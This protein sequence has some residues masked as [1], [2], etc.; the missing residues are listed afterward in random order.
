[1]HI[2]YKILPFLQDGKFHSGAILA[3]SLEISRSNIW[4]GIQFLRGLGLPI[5]AV[6]GRG[7]R[8]HVPTEL[9]DK[10]CIMKM[11][12]P[13]VLAYLY[14][15]DLFHVVTSTNDY[16]MQR[17]AD[18][19]SGTVCLAEAQTQ[20]KGRQ[21]KKWISP[22]GANIYLSLYHCFPKKLLDLSGLSLVVALAILEMLQGVGPLPLAL[23]IKWPND[24]WFE[25]KKLAGIL[26]E[27]LPRQDTTDIVIGIGLNVRLPFTHQEG[28]DLQ[29]IFPCVPSR[30]Q[31]LANLLNTLVPHLILFQ[32]EGFSAFQ[33]A[34]TE[35]DLLRNKKVQLK[36]KQN[37]QVGWAEGVNERG[38]LC[39]RIDGVLKAI[40]YGEISVRQK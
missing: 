37:T 31:L 29:S 22:Y 23:G 24:V 38:E 25:N 14:Q 9:L 39:V 17:V 4:K 3:K 32:Q 28:A 40:R 10:M 16:L 6:T 20:G 36:S 15:V 11:L 21:G 30:N 12:S 5:Q 33:A 35:Y 13:Q 1:M 2:A 34:W 8:W 19:E 26:I 27:S 18:L 7:Y